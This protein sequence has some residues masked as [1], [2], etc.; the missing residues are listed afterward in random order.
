VRTTTYLGLLLGIA[1]V[2]LAAWA[3]GGDTSLFTHREALLLVLGG[4]FAAATLA[5]S[6]RTALHALSAASRLFVSP[7]VT[8][9][10][11][12]EALVGLARQARASGLGAIDPAAVAIRDPFL[13]AGLHLVTEEVAPERIEELLRRE[14]EVLSQRRAQAERLFEQMGRSAPLFG[15]AGT[16]LALLELQHALPGGAVPW[17][18]VAAALAATCYGLLLAGVLFFPLAGKVRTLDLQERLVRDQVVTGLLAI[19][20]GQ[21]PEYIRESLQ[22]F[23]RRN[24]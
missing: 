18:A 14:S 2:A 11:V 19:R 13:L 9:R 23:A 3:S 20:L 17:P 12:T 22:R 1:V 4:T 7:T 24:G 6:R 16:L 5:S 10:E 8:T 15:V 21:N